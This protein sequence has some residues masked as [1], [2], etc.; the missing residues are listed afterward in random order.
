MLYY[1]TYYDLLNSHYIINIY[2]VPYS[3]VTFLSMRPPG[4]KA[5]NV[6]SS[7]PFRLARSVSSCAVEGV[8]IGVSY[9][10]RKGGT[11]VGPEARTESC[12]S[13]KV[14]VF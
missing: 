8:I 13:R 1:A 9:P 7:A 4:L 11:D 10:Q 14:A 3:M 5:R 6:V 12:W 2:S